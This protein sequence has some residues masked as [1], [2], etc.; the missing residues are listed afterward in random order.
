M[1]EGPNISDSWPTA[2]GRMPRMPSHQSDWMVIVPFIGT[3]IYIHIYIYIN[4][5][6]IYIYTYII[7][8]VII[9]IIIMI[10]CDIT[11]LYIWGNPW[12]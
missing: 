3:Y 7:I 9:T 1:G 10:I 4:Y 2:I 11:K 12:G 6:Y 5:I 8:I